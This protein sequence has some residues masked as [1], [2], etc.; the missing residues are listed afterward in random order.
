MLNSRL[1]RKVRNSP[2]LRPLGIAGYRLYTRLGPT[3]NGPQGPCQQHSQGPA[4]TF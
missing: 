2:A 3:Q 1:A 4:R